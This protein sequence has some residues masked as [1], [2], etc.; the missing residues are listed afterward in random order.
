MGQGTGLLQVLHLLKKPL[1]RMAALGRHP[2]EGG[3]EAVGF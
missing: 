3:D 2:Q 1:H